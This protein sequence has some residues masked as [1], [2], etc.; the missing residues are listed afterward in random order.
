LTASPRSLPLDDDLLH[1]LLFVQSQFVVAQSLSFRLLR[2]LNVNRDS[3]SVS[4]D[5]LL[6]DQLHNHVSGIV[7]KL[8]HMCEQALARLLRR[9]WRVNSLTRSLEVLK[10][11]EKLDVCS[12]LVDEEKEDVHL[13]SVSN[14][15]ELSKCLNSLFKCDENKSDENIRKGVSSA[16]KDL[17]VTNKPIWDALL[18]ASNRFKHA[19]LDLPPM[20]DLKTRF[21]QNGPWFDFYPILL[22][23]FLDFSFFRSSHD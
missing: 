5:W 11:G 19:S 1:Q 16:L 14:E 23:L 4:L 9:V 10:D 7:I 18:L 20:S 12:C 13:P 17:L 2:E 6:R 8:R 3:K 21:K 22:G 15:K